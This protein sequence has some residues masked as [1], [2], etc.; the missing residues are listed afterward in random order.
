MDK[1][2]ENIDLVDQRQ[3]TL[4]EA[5]EKLKSLQAGS[6]IMVPQLIVIGDQ[7]SGKSSILEAFA[8]F[9]FPIHE[10]LCTRFPTK[11]ILKRSDKSLVKVR[12]EL[13]PGSRTDAEV[14]RLQNFVHEVERYSEFYWK[15]L[16]DLMAKAA[17]ALGVPSQKS[18]PGEQDRRRFTEDI[19]V[20]EKHGPDSPILSL[21]D[22]PGLFRADGTEQNQEDRRTVERILDQHIKEPTNLVLVVVS[23]S[24]A[25]VNQTVVEKVQGLAKDDA[26]LL[27]RVIPVLTHPDLDTDHLEGI[28]KILKGEAS[29][30]GGDTKLLHKCHVVRNQNKADRAVSKSFDVRDEQERRFFNE[31]DWLDVP[32]EQKGIE[33]LRKTLKSLCWT[34]TQDELR[35][36][37]I[38]K[39]KT[40]INDIDAYVKTADVRRSN[41]HQRREYLCDIAEDFER[42]IR[43][44]VKG[45]YEDERCRELHLIGERESCRRCR[46]FFPDPKL[47]LNTNEGQQYKL[48]SNIRAMNKVFAGTMRRF[49]RSDVIDGLG[50][51]EPKVTN[52]ET[53][54]QHNLKSPSRARNNEVAGSFLSADVLNQYYTF[55]EPRSISRKD[56][57]EM[58]NQAMVRSKGREPD[59][60]PNWIV[61]RDLFRYQ[62]ARWAKIAEKHVQ[63]VCEEIGKYLNLALERACI[64]ENVRRAIHERIIRP[65]FEILQREANRTLSHLLECHRTGNPGFFDS[66]GDVF[67]VQ[68]QTKDLAHRLELLSGGYLEQVLGKDL[69]KNMK[70][71]LGILMW[72]SIS[73]ISAKS[74]L[75]AFVIKKAYD[76]VSNQFSQSDDTN[77]KHARSKKNG[78]RPT[79]NSNHDYIAAGVIA[80]VENYYKVRF[81]DIL[82]LLIFPT[83]SNHRRCRPP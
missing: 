49:G 17:D 22:L 40:K 79:F 11:L 57:E 9:H 83:L 28:K 41:D 81:A 20:I 68:E 13:K 47:A 10:S 4:F 24:T 35:R 60:E 32:P 8:Q 2:G 69:A 5:L 7:S 18:E 65:N 63:A 72:S 59:G 29:L 66:F 27:D 64:D 31:E 67:T 16:S 25:T 39:I 19:L 30:L 1:V 74:G 14:A 36:T 46:G 53:N 73:P 37:I 21:V 43:E 44:G 15:N 71:G 6:D 61:Y 75:G 52:V 55:D 58:V 77:Q 12:F 48:C 70:E 3:I 80:G 62:S 51:R 34:R 45:E 78:D 76:I 82:L 54:A 23:A 33:S 42:L 38:P 26:K 56:Y 50:G